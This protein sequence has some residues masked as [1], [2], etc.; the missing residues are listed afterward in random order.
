MMLAALLCL[1]LAPIEGHLLLLPENTRAKF[2]DDIESFNFKNSGSA[3]TFTSSSYSGTTSGGRAYTAFTAV[4][5][6]GLPASFGFELPAGGRRG[7]EVFV[8][9]VFLLPSLQAVLSFRMSPTLHSCV[10][11]HIPPTPASS[12]ILVLAWEMWS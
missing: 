5:H 4:V 8:S 2:N 6:N 11:A 1:L 7:A 10:T 3:G 9:V 12:T